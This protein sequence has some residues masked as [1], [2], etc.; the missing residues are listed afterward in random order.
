MSSCRSV[1]GAD[2][3]PAENLIAAL[4]SIASQFFSSSFRDDTHQI[5]SSS[6]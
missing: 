6:S 3:L 5:Q 2:G 1:F 4:C